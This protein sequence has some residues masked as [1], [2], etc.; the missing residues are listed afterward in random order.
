[1]PTHHVSFFL[2]SMMIGVPPACHAQV[3][4]AQYDN[5]RSGADLHERVLR[6]SNV[7]NRTFGK[8]FSRTVDGDIFTQPLYVP[9]LAIPGVGRHDVVFVATEHDSVY[10]FD[11]NGTRDVPLWKT[12]FVDP[13][14][15]TT[16]VSDHDLFCPFITP[17]VGITPTP[18]I[19]ATTKT[20]YVLAR[21][22]EHGA[23]VQK[24]HALDITSG[25]ERPGSPVVVSATVPGSGDGSVGGKVSF[26]PL[27][28]NPR[29]ALLL[30]GGEVYVTWAS[31]CDIG[32]YH[33]WV[34]AY[35][36]RTL[37]QRAVLNTSPDGADAGIWQSDAGPA[38]D[39]EGN[40]YVATGNGDFNGVKDGGRDFGD[41]VLKL[42]LEG[43][44]LVVRDYFTPF[45]QKEMDSKDWDL[46]SQGPVLLP[47]QAGA[48]PHLL[49]VAG[50][51]GKLYVLDRDRLGKFHDGSD[52]QIVQSI[53]AKDAYGAVAYW[54]GHVFF[55][56]RSDTTRDFAI[57]NGLLVQK[58]VTALMSSP[59]ATPI[60]SA[61]RTRDAILWVISTKEWD[62]TH[63]DR[64]A[65]LHAYDAR[66]ITHELY[67]S[68][69]K[70]Q[71]DRAH[72]TVRFAIPTIADGHVFIG[73]RGRLDV[74]GLLNQGSS[75]HK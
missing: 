72:M 23:F 44:N 59:G 30:V 42:R 27:K 73:T 75:S 74:Y 62:E 14:Q 26:D 19:D 22:K 17:E 1:M 54:N 8:L 2:L 67:S 61:D 55:T 69:Q 16:T 65:I 28:E 3:L 46:G 18:V 68:E 36:A 13:Q 40:V 37:R 6:P 7:D 51:E 39:N 60:I 52:S 5:F 29:A 38:A 45:N 35:D 33:G 12:S 64:P 31:S 10:A 57:E 49:V 58:G 32:P 24:L 21:T 34:M 25:K 70:S 53:K 9:S 56:D 11:V 43:Q 71:R 47:P 20:M 50:K 4:T 66:D 41:S 63:K 15:G 48:H